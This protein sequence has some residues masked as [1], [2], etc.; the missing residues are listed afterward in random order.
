[1]HK[2]K[3]KHIKVMIYQICLVTGVNICLVDAV[4]YLIFVQSS[5]L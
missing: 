2:K 5:E 1:M 3:H 4:V